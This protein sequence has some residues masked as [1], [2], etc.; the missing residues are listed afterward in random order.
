MYLRSNQSANIPPCEECTMRCNS[1]FRNLDAASLQKLSAEKTASVYKKGQTIFY[2]NRQ[3]H[4][5]YCIFS[6]KVKI[7]KYGEDGQEQIVRF[8]RPGSLIGYRA[9]LNGD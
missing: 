2:E 6:G 8:A 9:M 7:H 1:M 4:G 3:P 5:V